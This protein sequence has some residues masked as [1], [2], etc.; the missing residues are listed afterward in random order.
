MRRNGSATS[1]A[2]ATGTGGF[3]AYTSRPGNAY[4]AFG[5]NA[6]L[7]YGIGY[8]TAVAFKAY[9]KPVAAA[10]VVGFVGL[11]VASHLGYLPESLNHI[12][13]RVISH[14]DVSGDGD[15]DVEDVNILYAR[16]TALVAQGGP[17]AAGFAGGFFAGLAG[18]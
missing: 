7:S 4:T 13:Q 8:Q 12:Q 17:A 10:A 5:A 6:G 14:L 9:G 15:V 1:T 16:L 11:Q 18:Q 3:N 2:A